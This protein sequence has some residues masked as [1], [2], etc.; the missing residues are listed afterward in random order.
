MLISG[1]TAASEEQINRL[2]RPYGGVSLLGS[3]QFWSRK[4]S[5]NK[6]VR[7]KLE[8]AG[9]WT[10]LYANPQNTACSGDKLVKGPFGVLWFGEP[11]PQRM[12]ERHGR[13][14]S[15]VSMN[16][17]LFVQG[18][19]VIMAYDAYNGTFLWERQITGAVRVRADVDGG[20][21]ALTEDALY[22]AAR[23]KCYWLDPA[24]GK[25]IR[26]YEVP[27][28]PDGTRRR[29][30]YV[31][32]TDGILFGVTAMPLKMEYAAKYKAN[33]PLPKE[34]AQQIQ[35]DGILWGYNNSANFPS[36]NSRSSPK[37]A[38]TNR[39]MCGDTIFAMDP[40]TGRLL[41]RYR[42]E[43]IPNI[44]ITI[45]DGTVFFVEAA[46]T[47]QQKAK[48]LKEKQSLLKKGI[49][50]EA[51]REEYRLKDEDADVRLVVA[52]DATT[53]KT[54]WKKPLDLTGC[55]G[56]KVGSA[57]ADGLLLFFGQFSNHDQI[58]FKEDRLTWRRITALSAKTGKVLWSRPLNYLRRPLIVG[59]KIIVE[60]RACNLYTG[61]IITRTHPIT[62]REVPWEFLRP[63]HSCG[64]VSASTDTL[65]YRSYWAAIYELTADRG[66]SLFG[67]IR[68]GCW[69]N[70][71]PAGG[72][73][74]M[75][76]AS[77]GCTC[78]Y[79]LRCSVA[80]VHKPSKVTGNWT[81]FITPGAMTPVK[82]LA[83]NFGAPGDMKDKNGVVWFGYPRLQKT[84][85]V[86]DAYP[87]YGVRFDLNEKFVPEMGYFCRDYRGINITGSDK[88][89]LFTPGCRGL[90]RCE[91]PLIDDS[92]EQKPGIYTVRLGFNAPPTDRTGRRIFD[93]KLQDQLVLK[94]F[95]IL[96]TAGKPGKAV[97]KEF[98]GVRVRN[99][100]V[101]E[102]VPKAQNP[103]P[104][105]AP[106]INFIEVIRENADETPE[107]VSGTY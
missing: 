21:L 29:W 27:A 43:K 83:V 4:I 101:L 50:I 88:P 47:E 91:L 44:S 22:V 52:L 30:G 14:A 100:L 5:W 26:S 87:Q 97:I 37:N 54:L 85:S 42:G 48:A 34:K 90:L 64:I 56:D 28:S 23:D 33:L 62:G 36:W 1:K 16:G 13:A 103:K 19:E 92:A 6:F 18:E 94:K 17:R 93:I 78:S 99:L 72:L 41:W 58:L 89:W 66:L 77:S 73:M 82:H 81:I 40:Q 24:T 102:L 15:P 12:V 57:Y 2:L 96:Q 95:D 69:L 10:Q 63:G 80:M 49:Y 3:R 71:I 79:P 98:K 32:C 70:Q 104:H 84:V 31:S 67:A 35:R 75:P 61:E 74:L 38:L 20:N 53:G 8:G 11:G 76:E 107:I 68:P 59:D 60:P 46:A 9:S 51:E 55:G 86:S 65:F 39:L 106:L 25:T 7:G 45:A 105:Q